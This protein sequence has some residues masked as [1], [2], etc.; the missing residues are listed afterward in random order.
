M[1]AQAC[2]VITWEAE[3]KNHMFKTNLATQEHHT[4]NTRKGSGGEDIIE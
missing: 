2:D 3:T 1:V 4:Q